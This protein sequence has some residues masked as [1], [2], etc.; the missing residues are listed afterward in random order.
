MDEELRTFMRSFTHLTRLA[1]EYQQEPKGK[2]L[3]PVLA[4]HLGVDPSTVALVIE[5]F[6]SH[7]LADANIILDGLTSRDSEAKLVGLSGQDRHHFDLGDLIGVQGNFGVLGEPS[8]TSLAVGPGKQRRFLSFGIHLFSYEQV[9]IA[10]LLRQANPEY[11]KPEATLEVLCVNSELTD[12]FLAEFR[13]GLRTTSVYRGHVISFKASEY[14]ESNSGV[15]FH[16]REAISGEQLILPAGLRERIEEQVLGVGTH[17][18]A[19]LAYGAHLKRGVLLYGP[20][21]TGK[22]HTVRY[23]ASAATEHTV[24]LLNGNTL[25]LV[26]QAS[27]MARALQPSIVVLEDCD[28]VAEDRSFGN[29]PQPL[30]FEVLDSMDGLDSDADVSFVLTTNRVESLE[31]ALVQRP[32]RIDLAVQIP[33]PDYEAR[34]ALLRLYGS[35]LEL[36]EETIDSVAQKTEGTTASFTRELIR[37]AILSAAIAGVSVSAQHVEDAA[38]ALMDDSESLTRDFLGG[39]QDPDLGTDESTSEEYGSFGWVSLPETR[40]LGFD[41]GAGTSTDTEPPQTEDD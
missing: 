27:A 21:G 6:G 2:L 10:V 38:T 40:N 20:P 33:R 35:K 31:S 19:L 32:G 4:E 18:E 16:E 17:R 39:T 28:L 12:A 37:R 25:S 26:S 13:E 11:G 24:I 29:G 9:P 22:T 5:S 3:A 8:Y 30:L 15:T 14:S 1:E 36:P 23:L 7:R 34:K 41:P